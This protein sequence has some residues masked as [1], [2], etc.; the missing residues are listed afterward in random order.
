MTRFGVVCLTLTG[1]VAALAVAVV[2]TLP[3]RAIG[4]TPTWSTEAAACCVVAS[5]SVAA[6]AGLRAVHSKLVERALVEAL[7]AHE[8][9]LTDAL[10]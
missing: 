8:A 5:C 10:A 9:R 2:W 3:F 7:V 1:L 6:R 4:A